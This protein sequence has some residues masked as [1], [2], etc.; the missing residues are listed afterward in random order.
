MGRWS[1]NTAITKI[2]EKPPYCPHLCTKYTKLWMIA[3]YCLPTRHT[4]EISICTVLIIKPNTKVKDLC[5]YQI[6]TQSC[7]NCV[8]LHQCWFT[9]DLSYLIWTSNYVDF[10]KSFL[11]WTSNCVEF[12]KSC[13]IWTS[14]FAFNVNSLFLS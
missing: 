4:N 1:G 13:L 7:M 6:H 14:N 8:N 11:I 5:V 2:C 3:S 9:V 10:M 12:M